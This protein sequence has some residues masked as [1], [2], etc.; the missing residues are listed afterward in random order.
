MITRTSY[1]TIL[2]AFARNEK[3]GSAERA[4]ELLCQLEQSSAESNFTPSVW[5]YATVI[6]AFALASG[7]EYGGLPAVEKAKEIYHELVEKMANGLIRGEADCYANSCLLNCC[8]NIHGTGAEKRMALVIAVSDD[9]II[10]VL[11]F[12]LFHELRSF[13]DSTGLD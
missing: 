6:N 10:S 12:L 4:H 9:L 5:S 1:D 13:F 11:V 2:N 3:G 7:K 8:A